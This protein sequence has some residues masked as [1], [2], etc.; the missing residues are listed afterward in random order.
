M[1]S[2]RLELAA[3]ASSATILRRTLA[4]KL[5]EQRVDEDDAADFTLAVVEAF[6]N[7]VRHGAASP[8]CVILASLNFQSTTCSVTLDYPGEPFRTDAPRLPAAFSTG[9]RGRYLMT[10]LTDRVDY[11]FRCGMT[12]VRLLKHWRTG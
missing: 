2:E 7:A 10:V 6:S 8:E 9:G 12:R 5:N 3:A 11:E 4:Q 1:D